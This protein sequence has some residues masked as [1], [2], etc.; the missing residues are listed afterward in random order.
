MRISVHFHRYTY[1]SLSEL[2]RK[3]SSKSK[4]PES[5]SLKVSSKCSCCIQQLKG[6]RILVKN[7]EKVCQKWELFYGEV[8]LLTYGCLYTAF[9]GSGVNSYPEFCHNRCCIWLQGIYASPIACR[10]LELGLTV[11]ICGW[12]WCLSPLLALF[13]IPPRPL[14]VIFS[15]SLT[16]WISPQNNYL[17]FSL[18]LLNLKLL[19]GLICK[20]SKVLRE[21]VIITNGLY[22]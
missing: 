5:K 11:P 18:P 20:Q 16:M 3:S 13:Q 12:S 15:P 8:M 2:T 21:K 4:S 9:G 10:G 1:S 17:G 7:C 19:S 14:C 22:L 6:H